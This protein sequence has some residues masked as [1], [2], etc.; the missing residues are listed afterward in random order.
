M[1]IHNFLCLPES[2]DAEVQEDTHLD[3]RPTLQR[4]PFYCTPHV[5]ANAVILDPTLEDL[6]VGTPSYKILDKAEASQ[7]TT[8]P[9][10]FMDNSDDRS[11]DD[12]DDDGDDACLEIPLVTPIRSAAVI[13]SL[14]NQYGSSTTPATKGPGTRGKGIM[15]NNADAPSVGVSQIRLSFRPAPSFRDVSRDVIHMDFFPFSASPYHATYPE[16]AVVRNFKFNREEW[17]ALYRPTFGVLTKEVF[18]DPAMSVLHYMMM[19]H[20]GELLARYRGLNQSHHEYVLSIDSRLSGYEEKVAS[21]NGLELQVFTLKKQTKDEFADVLKKMTYFVPVVQGRLAEASPLMAQTN[22]AFLNKISEHAAEPLFVILELEPKK[23]VRSANVP[24]SKDA[25]V[26]PPIIKV[27]TVTP[28]SG[29]LDLLANVVPAPSVVALKQNEEWVNDMVDGS[30]AEM[31]DGLQRASSSLTDVVVALSIGEKGEGRV[32]CQRTLVA[33]SL[34]KTD[35]RCVVVHPAD[36]ESCQPSLAKWLPPRTFS[37]AGQASV[38]A[39]SPANRVSQSMTLSDVLKLMKMAYE[40]IFSLG[41]TRIIPIPE[42]S[43]IVSF[44]RSHRKYLHGYPIN[45]TSSSPSFKKGHR[46]TF[47]FNTSLPSGVMG[48]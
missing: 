33:L 14:G 37:I 19:S 36:P 28:A 46:N 15:V 29:S 12:D 26:S 21:L 42:P 32:V 48:R 39:A 9:S 1:R 30:D 41:L 34:G 6:L 5:T 47:P 24:T 13:P 23:L 3:V 18:K 8:R 7:N 2:T 45:D 27:S 22:Y 44:P 25:R 11:D 40:C 31:T 10:L 17:D 16:G 38:E 35:C 43:L 4:L 20:G